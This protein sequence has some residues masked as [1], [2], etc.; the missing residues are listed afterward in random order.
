MKIILTSESLVINSFHCVQC[1]IN[2][3]RAANKQM[4]VKL[5]CNINIEREF[6]N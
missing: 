5:A 2:N 6:R 1:V 3:V 4:K